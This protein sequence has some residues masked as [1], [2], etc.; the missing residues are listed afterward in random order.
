MLFLI[1]SQS[2]L[3]LLFLLMSFLNC[4]DKK[5]FFFFDKKGFVFRILIEL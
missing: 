5:M 2:H 1:A 3:K 4:L